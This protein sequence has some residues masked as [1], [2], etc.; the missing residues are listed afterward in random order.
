L[1]TL[2]LSETHLRHLQAGV[3]SAWLITG[4]TEF[5]HCDTSAPFKK[6]FI[7]NIDKILDVYGP[8]YSIEKEDL[9]LGQSSFFSP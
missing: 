1:K 9:R 5:K 2:V 8:K 4:T 7:T 6:W 3:K